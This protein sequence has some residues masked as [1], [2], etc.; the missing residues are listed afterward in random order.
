MP[1]GQ[2]DMAMFDAA[3]GE[4]GAETG[5]AGAGAGAGEGAGAGAGAA[6][7]GAG[8]SAGGD[9]G[10]AQGTGTGTGAGLGTDGNPSPDGTGGAGTGERGDG[11][12]QQA[13]DDQN[14]QQTVPHQALHQEREKNKELRR[15][16]EELKAQALTPEDRAALAALRQQQQQA[17]EPPKEED[18]EP[19]FLKDPKAWAAWNTRKG[20]REARAEQ[21]RKESEAKAHQEEIQTVIN[22]TSASEQAFVQSTPDYPQALEHVRK[23]RMQQ[24]RLVNDSLTD[25]Q[26]INQI[27]LEEIALAQQVLKSNKDPA[28]FAYNYAK[29]I[30]YVP[31]VSGSGQQQQAQQQASAGAVTQKVDREAVRTLGASSDDGSGGE[32]VEQSEFAAAKAE[33]FSKK[34]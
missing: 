14:R 22:R 9:S 34:R 29:T 20:I 33:R 21:E 2:L 25:Q 30:G 3:E 32:L 17:K 5:T 10:Q 8:Q 23:V 4:S 18:P 1:L 16:L 7:A 15:Q 28:A 19:E 26:I 11:T 6:A 31:K 27:M 13:V 24:I 12:Q